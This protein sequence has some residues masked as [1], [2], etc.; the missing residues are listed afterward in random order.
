MPRG[1]QSKA[2]KR[3]KKKMVEDVAESAFS[4][5]KVNAFVDK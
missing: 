5:E 1:I 3:E 2:I 4:L